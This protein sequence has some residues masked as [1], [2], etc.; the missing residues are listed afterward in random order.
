MNRIKTLIAS[1]LTITA[2][3]AQIPEWVIEPKYDAI[4]RLSFSVYAF[5]NNGKW[6]II[7]DG[8]EILPASLDWLTPMANGYAIG[9]EIKDGKKLVGK[10]ISESGNITKPSYD[11]Y[12]A[13]SPYFSEG[14]LLVT[15]G[16]SF[17]Y[18]Y[19]IGPDGKDINHSSYE[20]ALPFRN[21]WAPIRDKKGKWKYTNPKTKRDLAVDFHNGDLSL[22]SC[23]KGGT[24][25][26]AHEYNYAEIGPTG[27]TIRTIYRKDEFDRLYAEKNSHPFFGEYDQLAPNPINVVKGGEQEYSFVTSDGKEYYNPTLFSHIGKQYNDGMII[28]GKGNKTG[29]LK[30]NPEQITLSSPS[31][32]SIETDKNGYYKSIK[33]KFTKPY[34]IKNNVQASVKIGTVD[35]ASKCSNSQ[36]EI[37][38]EF[39][40]SNFDKSL[41][42]VPI[43]VFLKTD[44]LYYLGK[45]YQAEVERKALVTFT[46]PKGGTRANDD[47]DII[48]ISSTIYNSSNIEAIANVKWSTSNSSNTYT[49]P[50]N[51]SKTVSTTIK[52]NN[53]RRTITLTVNGESKSLTQMFK[54][55]F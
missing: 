18:C 9:G 52:A 34:S 13:P 10:I 36:N 6:G 55:Y 49:I 23:F 42:T 25:V 3:Q 11:R 41:T 15:L 47:S 51:G 14:T 40:P 39:T 17:S 4:E 32:I 53:Q 5:S 37:I 30:F 43:T 22:A 29:V 27:K 20:K 19:F 21:G 33:L 26:V 44:G 8:K 48:T 16:D 28:V 24:A 2:A 54:T 38:V 1:L 12:T 46:D 45:I 35:V 50:A 7:K 31:K